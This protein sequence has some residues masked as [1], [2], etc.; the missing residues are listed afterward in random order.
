M[1]KVRGRLDNAARRL[2]GEMFINAE[3]SMPVKAQVHLPGKAVFFQGGTSYVFVQ[4]GKGSF[5]R[6]AVKPGRE[7][8]GVVEIL[9]GV[10]PGEQVVVQG[11]LLL[12]QV[13][14]DV[15]SGTSG[16]ES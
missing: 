2:K 5:T 6:R 13:L 1:V 14:Q 9:S 3:I 11:A 12:Q 7:R 15:R 10:T 8:G 16:K 4:D